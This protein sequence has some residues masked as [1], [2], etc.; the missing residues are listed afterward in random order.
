MRLA[1][2]IAALALTVLAMLGCAQREDLALPN[3]PPETYVSVA[4]SVKNPTVYIQ[5]ISW[6]GDDK[7]GEV[8]SYEYRWFIDPSEPACPMDTDWVLTQDTRQVFSLPVTQGSRVHRF[9]V[10]AIDDDG[11]V[12][13][14]PATLTL[15]VVNSPP[16]VMIWNETGLPDTTFPAILIKW[17]GDDPEGRETIMSYKVWLDGAEDHALVVSA[18][19][20][21]ASFGY[22][23]FAGRYGERTVYL[24]AVDTGCDTSEVVSHTWQVKDIAGEV[25]LVDDRTT[26][27]P[28][29]QITDAFYRNVLRDCVGVYSVLDIRVFGGQS[30]AHNFA[31]LFSKFRLV[32]WYNDHQREASPHLALAESAIPEYVESGG[33]FLLVSLSAIGT[34][35]SFLDTLSFDVFGVDSLHRNADKTSNF[36]CQLWEVQANGDLG[37]ENLKIWGIFKGLDCMQPLADATPLYYIPPETAIPAQHRNFYLGILNTWGSG[38]A[39]LLTFPFSRSDGYG[40]AKDEFCKLLHLMLD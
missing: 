10:R 18:H 4:D 26:D 19:D 27:P 32:V 24:V 6:W 21:T 9:E 15:P 35:A 11:A 25:L 38:K 16:G 5:T 30:Y 20:T 28:G 12:D 23:D 37:L 13:P 33:G 2:L 8:V 17:H 3:L 39:V 29:Y 31:R 34:E 22:D 1:S 36:D 7:D 40:N 14:S